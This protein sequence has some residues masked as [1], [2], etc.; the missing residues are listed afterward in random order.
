MG[1]VLSTTVALLAV[2]ALAVATLRLLGRRAPPVAGLRVVARLSLDARRALYV[3]EAGGRCLLLGAGDGA[4]T[5][6]TELD[7]GSV[8]ASEPVATLDALKRA[9]GLP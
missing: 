1:P 5:L 8:P 2:C 7:R 4:L 3:V 9:M 6:L